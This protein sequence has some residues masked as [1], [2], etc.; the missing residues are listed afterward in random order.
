MSSEWRLDEVVIEAVLV[1]GEQHEVGG[2][3]VRER[4]Q[5]GGQ[6][7]AILALPQKARYVRVDVADLGALGLK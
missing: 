7:E 6:V 1:G 2:C 5:H 4:V 3:Q